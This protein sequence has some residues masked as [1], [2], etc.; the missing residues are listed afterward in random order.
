MSR[1]L[2]L[3]DEA[4]VAMLIEDLLHEL[5]F[6]SHSCATIS[7]AVALANEHDYELA[8][9]DV[10]LGAELTYPAA[11]ALMARGIPFAFA[12]GYGESGIRAN[13]SNVPVLHKPFDRD[14]MAS[15]LERLRHASL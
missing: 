10:N 8:I 3:E 1:V 15:I 13:Y 11:D 12:T 9:L 5:G 7:E 2:I 6:E 4:L 14:R